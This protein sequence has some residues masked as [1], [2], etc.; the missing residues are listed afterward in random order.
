M[1]DQ[2]EKDGLLN[3]ISKEDR[4]PNFF[5]IRDAYNYEFNEILKDLDKFFVTSH[6]DEYGIP[7]PS[8]TTFDRY[9]RARNIKQKL[10]SF[11]RDIE[12]LQRHIYSLLINPANHS[13]LSVLVKEYE[14]N[15]KKALFFQCTLSFNE[16]IELRHIAK[17]SAENI[18]A[19]TLGRYS[20]I[21]SEIE[22]TIHGTEIN[23]FVIK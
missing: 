6:K 23:I 9:M 5:Q 10:I 7:L 15:G 11:D 13:A 16:K 18:Y 17:H 22:K 1:E 4:N 2:A 20:A 12:L 14:K 19:E 21:L 3:W 8:V